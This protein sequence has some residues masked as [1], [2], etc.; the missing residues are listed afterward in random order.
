MPGWFMADIEIKR[1]H[2]IEC[3]LGLLELLFEVDDVFNAA[4]L[5]ISHW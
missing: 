4:S 1:I 5:Q 3:Q 2:A